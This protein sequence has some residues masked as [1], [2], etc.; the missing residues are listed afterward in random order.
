MI[1]RICNINDLPAV[2]LIYNEGIRNQ[3]NA[4]SK[5]LTLTEQEQ[6]FEVHKDPKFPVILAIDD[7]NEIMGWVSLSPYRK[8][9]EALS[10]STEISYYV[11]SNHFRK[12]VGKS[13]V[14]EAEKI[15]RQIGHHVIFAITIA[16]NIPSHKLLYKMGYEK[17]GEMKEIACFDGKFMDQIYFGKII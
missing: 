14:I 17:W 13:L 1:F 6:W 5:E 9:R 2:N 8:G 10:R 16:S 12:G 7:N 11:S 4:R 3:T 15:A